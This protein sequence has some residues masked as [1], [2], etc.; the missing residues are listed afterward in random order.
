MKKQQRSVVVRA[1]L[2]KKN[3]TILFFFL[4]YLAA[5]I[6]LLYDERLG[7]P[8]SR[9]FIVIMGGLP[10]IFLAFFVANIVTRIM[11]PSISRFFRDELDPE[12]RIF[13]VKLFDLFVYLATFA[14]ILYSFGV[15]LASL[16]TFLG[17]VTVGLAL[18]V[19]E[20]VLSFFVWLIILNKRPFRMG[21]HIRIG[22]YE[23]KVER[24]G[25]FFIQL[26][27]A[28]RIDGG[29][30]SG[31]IVKLPN[32]IILDSPLENYGKSFREVV[33]ISLNKQL[34]DKRPFVLALRPLTV[35]RIVVR[36]DAH[37]EKVVLVVEFDV[38]AEN[39]EAARS[40]VIETAQ[41]LKLC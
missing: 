10:L 19:R 15:T 41:K 39:R 22:A 2:R 36:Q 38:L 28:K 31:F 3:F 13:F 9:E 33:S 6:F 11:G 27:S 23:G 21:D 26:G 18:A 1:W 24:I 20:P 37:A 40:V 8:V 32:K 12:Q 5:R 4:L 14:Y 35:G 34:H 29:S 16:A 30:M 25:T 7:L 17:F